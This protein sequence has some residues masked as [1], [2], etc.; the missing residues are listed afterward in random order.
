MPSS[1]SHVAREC[2]S[3]PVGVPAPIRKRKILCAFYQKRAIDMQTAA[4]PTSLV[5]TTRCLPR[6]WGTE[7][8]N[9]A[10]IGSKPCGPNLRGGAREREAA[11]LLTTGRVIQREQPIRPLGSD[12]MKMLVPDAYGVRCVFPMTLA[13]CR[14]ISNHSD[15]VTLSKRS[16]HSRP[17]GVC[18]RLSKKSDFYPRTR[19]DFSWFRLV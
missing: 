3:C 19:S 11:L 13:V 14:R 7:I 18:Q 10:P 6:P 4:M 17:S 15:P 1:R 2:L 16:V 9:Q 12:P 8:L 5:T